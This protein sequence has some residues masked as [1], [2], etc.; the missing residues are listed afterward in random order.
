MTVVIDAL[1]EHAGDQ[2]VTAAI[3]LLLQKDPPA[4]FVLPFDS[5]KL[6]V[7]VDG[8]EAANVSKT[9]ARC[10][11]VQ[12]DSCSNSGVEAVLNA[13]NNAVELARDAADAAPAGLLPLLPSLY[14]RLWRNYPRVNE[15]ATCDAF[16]DLPAVAN[17]CYDQDQIGVTVYEFTHASAIADPPTRDIAIGY[18]ASVAFS[19]AQALENADSYRARLNWTDE[20]AM[21]SIHDVVDETASSIDGKYIADL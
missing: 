1:D 11:N 2:D 12:L 3:K 21:L 15:I 13:V 9:L 10:T 20:D 6:T 8:D 16:Y 19:A 4:V 5:N 18:S 14:I 17:S 7:E